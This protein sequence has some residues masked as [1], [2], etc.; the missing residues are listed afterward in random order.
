MMLK[1]QIIKTSSKVLNFNLGQNNF[2]ESTCD[3]RGLKID[4]SYDNDILINFY[5]DSNNFPLMGE[6]LN[7]WV[8]NKN[9]KTVCLKINQNS[10]CFSPQEEIYMS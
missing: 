1:N 10:Q 9:N 2:N 4:Y 6:T 3:I 8:F 5:R 7:E